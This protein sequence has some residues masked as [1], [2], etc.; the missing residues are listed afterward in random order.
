MHERSLPVSPLPAVRADQGDKR[1]ICEGQGV[2]ELNS[3]QTSRTFLCR[4]CNG[5]GRAPDKTSAETALAA[6]KQK[7]CS[8][9]LGAGQ[10]AHGT[11]CRRCLGQGIANGPAKGDWK[12]V[13][14]AGAGGVIAF[15]LIAATP[16][17]LAVSLGGAATLGT[18]AVAMRWREKRAKRKAKSEDRA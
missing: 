8:Y 5:E 7:I 16:V 14:L 15:G 9:C 18:A 1:H 6:A 3:F 12:R 4:T 11:A 2:I 17:A 10:N 13:A